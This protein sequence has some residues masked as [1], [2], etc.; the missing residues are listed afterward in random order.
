MIKL[1]P[2]YLCFFFISHTQAYF[3]FI[4]IKNMSGKYLSGKGAARAESAKYGI[5]KIKIFH[6]EVDLKINEKRL[7]VKN[8][9]TKVEFKFKSS[10]F[11]TFKAFSF[12]QLNVSSDKKQFNLRS[13]DLEFFIAPKKYS[14]SE[15][16][17]ETDISHLPISARD[18]ITIVDGLTLNAILRMRKVSF[19]GFDSSFFEELRKENP[20]KV[21][22]IFQIQ[23]KSKTFKLPMAIRNIFFK[24]H[25]GQLIGK[26]KIDSYINLW[27]RI[28]GDI[29]TNREN[30]FIKIYVRRAKL[31]FFSVRTVLMN[32]VSDLDLDGVSVDGY[33]IHIDLEHAS[34]SK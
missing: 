5:D 13:D 17:I 4:K 18:D 24:V 21:N 19:S 22:H 31:G 32:M 30:S 29:K 14:L 34:L 15:F 20:T 23:K 16:Q 26:A 28:E 9:M 11:N 27:F 12:H 8:E 33:T 3:P 25:K 7:V 1:L 6:K 2:F 10:F